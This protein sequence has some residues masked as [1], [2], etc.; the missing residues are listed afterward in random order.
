M[1]GYLVELQMDGATGQSMRL[2]IE[3][4][5]KLGELLLWDTM[6][7]DEYVASLNTGDYLLESYGKVIDLSTPSQLDTFFAHFP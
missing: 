5:D 3:S 1:K 4:T 7:Y 6:L 2:R